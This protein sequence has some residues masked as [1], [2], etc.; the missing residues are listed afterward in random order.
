MQLMR[1][2]GLIG[3]LVVAQP[4]LATE[5]PMLEPYQV[6]RSLG[7]LQDRIANGEQAALPLQGKLLAMADKIFNQTPHETLKKPKN[8]KA[9]L[10]YGLTGGNPRT[11]LSLAP[12]IPSEDP[13]Y[14]LAEGVTHYVRGQQASARKAFE[15]VDPLKLD[16]DIGA[17][18]ALAVGSANAKDE[19]DRAIEMLKLA[20]VQAPGSLIE[21]AA[22]RRLIA[23]YLHVGDTAG[24]VKA[25]ERYARRFNGSPYANQFADML[26]SGTANLQVV[27]DRKQIR[28]VAENL[29]RNQRNA[30]YLR[31][32]RNAAVKGMSDLSAHISSLVDPVPGRKQS[33][34][35]PEP[36]NLAGVED[37]KVAALR[38]KL[39]AGISTLRKTGDTEPLT[40]LQ[41][42]AG[43]KLPAD[44][45]KLLAAALAVAKAIS[46]PIEQMDSTAA[47]S[48]D[49]GGGMPDNGN[50]AEFEPTKP[51]LAVLDSAEALI[52]GMRQKLQSIDQRIE[53]ETR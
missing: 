31:V 29:P 35:P 32:A 7:V 43:D 33:N 51:D 23:M 52:S 1:A 39:Y 37:D 45:R 11:V 30:I 34:S 22:L 20:I 49:E 53:K 17:S 48:T 24:F 12:V 6:M 47:L 3:A 16:G 14:H 4:A 41:N 5:L 38:S 8:I 25:S 9:L 36:E 19:P 26:V 13:H 15:K 10:I 27:P 46:E 21:E 40:E 18:V 50:A 2:A 42:M 44:D 28:L